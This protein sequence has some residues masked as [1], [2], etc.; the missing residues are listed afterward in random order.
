METN[1]GIQ[2]ICALITGQ[3]IDQQNSAPVNAFNAANSYI[4]V[5]DGNG[6]VPTV[7][8]SDTQLVAAKS[9][10]GSGNYIDLTMVPGFPKVVAET[11]QWEIQAGSTVGNFAWNE[12]AVANGSVSQVNAGGSTARYILNHKGVALGT[13]VSGEVWTIQIAITQS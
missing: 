2:E 5:G 8:A 10:T 11:M 1:L 13:K 7:A 9:G 6:S 12:M 3:S 4:F